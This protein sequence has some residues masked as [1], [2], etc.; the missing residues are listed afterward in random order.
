MGPM[1]KVRMLPIEQL[2]EAYT[3]TG[4]I[5]GMEKQ[6]G[7]VIK[8]PCVRKLIQH[9]LHEHDPTLIKKRATRNAYTIND[10]RDAVVD[11]ICMS[12]VLRKLG[13]TTHGECANVVKALMV[14]H[15]IDF[16]HFNSKH[17]TQ[18]N[19]HRWTVEQVF[20]KNSPIPR[21][22]LCNHVRRFNVLGQPKCV[23]CSVENMYNNKPL[24]L[25]VDH[26][27]GISDDNRI[28]NLRWLCPNCHSQTD[29]YCGKN[30][31][32]PL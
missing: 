21:A 23:S 24:K 11:S 14:H 9:R 17:A 7:I 26:I 3:N 15:K 6:L 18:R 28:E 19:K 12:D 10:I 22:T 32:I 25:T 16:T 2:V 1:E 20:I 8:A 30:K 31:N 4:S 5:R 29:T 13:L 27:N